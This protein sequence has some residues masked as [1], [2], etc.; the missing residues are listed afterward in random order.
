MKGSC[1]CSAAGAA[2]AKTDENRKALNRE[3]GMSATSAAIGSKTR[4]GYM[5]SSTNYHYMAA[6]TGYGSNENIKTG[7]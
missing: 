3:A 7:Y 4:S 6:P 5:A 1:N 2:M